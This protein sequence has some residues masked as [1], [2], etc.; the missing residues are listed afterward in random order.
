MAR[1]WSFSGVCRNSSDRIQDSSELGIVAVGEPAHIPV[2]G[3]K[4]DDLFSRDQ[5]GRR[6]LFDDDLA[7]KA[8]RTY[9]G[10]R[11]GL[12]ERD[13][14]KRSQTVNDRVSEPL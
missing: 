1:S 3:V 11:L 2:S 9:R 7:K 6:G 12:V 14:F 10:F 13:N 8:T 5:Q 4:G